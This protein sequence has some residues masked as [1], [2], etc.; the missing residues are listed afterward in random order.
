MNH[1][2]PRLGGGDLELTDD[3]LVAQSR[4]GD[5]R[6]FRALV[7]KYQRRAYGIALGIL[8]NPE[9]AMDASQNAFIKV[10]RNLHGFKGDSS[11]YTWLYRIVVNVCIDHCRKHGKMKPVE[12]DE[13]FRR[14]DEA[15]VVVPL[16][17]N[18]KPMHPGAKFENDE[19]RAQL[20]KALGELSENHRSI[21]VLREVEGLSYEEIA[22]VMDCHLGTVMSRLHHARKNL[23]KALKPYLEASDSHLADQAGAGV[24]KRS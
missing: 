18:T 7:E 14:R 5:E 11:F 13:T 24:R 17:G 23:Q 12:Y 21:I 19:L 2:P 15:A 16:S 9:D 6:A 8:R 3:E 1:S 4:A 22:E 10:F 20:N